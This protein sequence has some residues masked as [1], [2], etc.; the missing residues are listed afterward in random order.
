MNWVGVQPENDSFGKQVLKVVGRT[1]LNNWKNDPAI[2]YGPVP[3]KKSVFDS[4]EDTDSNYCLALLGMMFSQ[5]YWEK[6]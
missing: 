3:I 2:T 1:V 6:S 4:L 5:C